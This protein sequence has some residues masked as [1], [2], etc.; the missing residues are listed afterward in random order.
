M[1]IQLSITRYN[2]PIKRHEPL[3]IINVSNNYQCKPD[4]KALT[5]NNYQW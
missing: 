2:K 5:I 3:I 4:Q 1:L